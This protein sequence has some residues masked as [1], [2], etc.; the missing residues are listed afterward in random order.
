MIT[1]IFK[2]SLL[3]LGIFGACIAQEPEL[4]PDFTENHPSDLSTDCCNESNVHRKNSANFFSETTQIVAPN[5][6]VRFEEHNFVSGI[7]INNQNTKMKFAKSGTYLIIFDAIGG[8]LID[9]SSNTTSFPYDL[10]L[11]L[12]G[13]LVRGSVSTA[14]DV[15]DENF[16]FLTRVFGQVIIHIRK[17]DILELRNTST[18]SIKVNA[19]VVPGNP[20]IETSASIS[21]VKI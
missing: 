8:P 1:Q 4:T 7:A 5:Q 12:N 16:L 10:G 15:T 9:S 18:T 19:D 20:V 3:F 21:I 17:G 2:S 11:F 13:N 6:P 14:T